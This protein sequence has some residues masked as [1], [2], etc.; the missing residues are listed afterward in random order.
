MKPD[1]DESAP[2]V[3]SGADESAAPPGRRPL[4]QLWADT[5]S[6]ARATAE[7]ELSLVRA[8]TAGNFKMLRWSFA[9]IG[10][11]MLFLMAALVL[12]TVAV[13]IWL[14]GMFGVVPTLLLLAGA[15]LLV[16]AWLVRSGADGVSL[17][18]MLPMVSIARLSRRAVPI[19]ETEE[20]MAATA[21]GKSDGR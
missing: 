9:R 2:A 17:R 14:T 21:G 7:A 12:A 10:I 8:E 11:G 1:A 3:K 20:A 6:G 18:R 16:G 4:G 5:I 15:Y 13:A 19:A